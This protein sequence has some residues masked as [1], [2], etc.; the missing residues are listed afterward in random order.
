MKSGIPSVKR[1]LIILAL[2][3][4]LAANASA[5]QVLNSFEEA[6]DINEWQVL[7]VGTLVASTDFFVN[8]GMYNGKL[9]VPLDPV[10]PLDEFV[11]ISID[12]TVYP[13]PP[14]AGEQFMALDVY[15][16]GAGQGMYLIVYGAATCQTGCASSETYVNGDN[17]VDEPDVLF[18]DM[19]LLGLDAP[20]S[21]QIVRPRLDVDHDTYM[22]YLRYTDTLE[23]PD[24]SGTPTPTRTISCTP[25]SSASHTMSATVSATDTATP[26]FTASASQTKSATESASLTSSASYTPTSTYTPTHT[27]TTTNTRTPAGTRTVT[28]TA[29]PSSTITR[30][31]TPTIAPAIAYPNPVTF[32]KPGAKLV[33]GN[34]RQGDEIQVY[35][36][37]GEK[38][39]HVKV[40]EI[41]AEN[42]SQSVNNWRWAWDGEND[43][44]EPVVTGLYIAVIRHAEADPERLKIAVIRP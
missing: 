33:F 31:F 23:P 20:T 29:T 42:G 41:E 18:I 35:T 2:A 11:T 40:A 43:N 24:L 44:G 32:D 12:L 19:A 25:T 16:A 4:S 15:V 14:R 39:R 5:Q 30:T 27:P 22:E 13:K 38:V 28:P 3:L 7:T 37:A 9:T 10:L 1:A 17:T 36:V 6:G 26:T 34:L 21:I 8:D